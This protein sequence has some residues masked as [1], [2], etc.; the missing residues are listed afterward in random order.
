[1]TTSFS[2]KS[3]GPSVIK[4][5]GG[6]YRFHIKA[7]LCVAHLS[8]VPAAPHPLNAASGCRSRM[9]ATVEWKLRMAA[10]RRVCG[11]PVRARG[12]QGEKEE[13]REE[14]EDGGGEEGR[15]GGARMNGGLQGAA[16]QL[17]TCWTCWYCWYCWR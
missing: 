12:E 8:C 6:D 14:E 10:L 16:E 2:S 1:M 11:L 7:F 15:V 17:W 4:D 3:G 13:D 9:D 5:K